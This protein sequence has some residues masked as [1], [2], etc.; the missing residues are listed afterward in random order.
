[1][2]SE[3]T[4]NKAT[5]PKSLPDGKPLIWCPTCEGYLPRHTCE[6]KV[7]ATVVLG[8]GVTAVIGVVAIMLS[9]V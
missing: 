5:E 6:W 1:M 4:I 2:K 8:A 3:L 9:L 7:L